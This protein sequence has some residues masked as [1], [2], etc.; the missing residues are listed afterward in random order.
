MARKKI[1]PTENKREKFLRL[2]T[3]R[4]NE[5]LGRL[6]ILGNCSNRQI[7]DYNE[8]DVDK[9]FSAIDKKLRE[10]RSKFHFPK[11][12]EFKL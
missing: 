3:Q 8:T 4:T 10:V 5:A 7:Y 6:R 2:A 9:I 1:S 11:K 12:E